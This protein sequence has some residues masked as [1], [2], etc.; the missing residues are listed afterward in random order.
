MRVEATNQS[1]KFLEKIEDKLKERIRLKI[2]KLALAID[3]DGIIPFKE[4]SIKKLDGSW[5]GYYR[6]IVGKVRIIFIYDKEQNVLFI[7]EIDFRGNI[8]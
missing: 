3:N 8:Y 7:N 5:K 6:M 2:R 4:L 1:L